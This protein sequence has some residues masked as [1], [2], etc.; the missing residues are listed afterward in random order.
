M[1]LEYQAQM[2]ALLRT[3]KEMGIANV[4]ELIETFGITHFSGHGSL[5]LRD[6]LDNWRS[7][8]QPTKYVVFQAR[9]DWNGGFSNFPTS[10]K[11]ALST[12]Q[13]AAEEVVLFEVNGVADIAK[14]IVSIGN[15]ERQHGRQPSVDLVIIGAHGSPDGIL[16]GTDRDSSDVE[17]IENV[18]ANSADFMKPNRYKRHL[19][20]H[21][22]VI[23]K[24]CSTAAPVEGG[25]NYARVLSKLL[26]TTVQGAPNLSRGPLIIDSDGRAIFN[27]G[28]IETQT[29]NSGDEL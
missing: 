18:L 2:D 13:A 6:Q 28:E 15:R 10:T 3:I 7:G 4:I 1:L 11:E 19:G 29:Y 23:L 26:Q 25:M 22:K 12:A 16:I 9:A 20:G 14:A 24:A 17:S 8:V 21:Y 5:E 27:N